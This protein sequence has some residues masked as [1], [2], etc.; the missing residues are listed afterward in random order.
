MDNYICQFL[1]RIVLW[2]YS[3]ASY[4]FLDGHR[5]SSRDLD[6]A[7]LLGVLGHILLLLAVGVKAADLVPVADEG[8][9]QV[10][11]GG[12]EGTAADPEEEADNDS[13]DILGALPEGAETKGHGFGGGALAA[14][15][16]DP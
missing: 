16:D 9:G 14:R 5:L 8:P 15:E 7:L 3:L 13:Q 10:H 6:V 1:A 12:G 4:L 2:K 11:G